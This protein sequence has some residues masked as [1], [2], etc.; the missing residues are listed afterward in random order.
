MSFVR[1]RRVSLIEKTLCFLFCNIIRLFA[2][3]LEPL[4]QRGIF[5]LAHSGKTRLYKTG[6]RS[7]DGVRVLILRGLIKRVHK[8]YVLS[9]GR[10]VLFGKIAF[11]H[12]V[13]SL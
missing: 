11:R 2:Q 12:F 5:R 8:T 13:Y 4:L 3:L 9:K 10:T 6:K 7:R 1:E